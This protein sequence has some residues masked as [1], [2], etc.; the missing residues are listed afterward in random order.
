[1]TSTATVI[2]RR[3]ISP[4]IAALV[5]GLSLLAMT[6]IAI[7][8]NFGVVSN[9]AVPGDPTA[10]AA[11]LAEAGSRVRFAGAGFVIVAI[12][13]IIV[14]WALYIVLRSVNP[15][16]SLLGG[17]LRLAYAA[18]LAVA[19]NSLLGAMRLAQIEP[20]MAYLTLVSFNTLWQIGLIVFGVHLAVVGF[21]VWQADFI[22]W[23]FGLL[24][25]ISGLGYI[26][27]GFGF[28]LSPTYSLNVAMFTFLGE[29]AFMFW[30]LIQGRQLSG[31]AEA[32]ALI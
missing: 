15:G 31:S 8:V 12:L 6:V 28:L 19:V 2:P 3:D 14:A 1:V 17:W 4:Q 29:L 25:I 11:N 18:I 23:I 9:L 30:L 26:I 20:S 21:L 5:A 27:D 7:A 32:P 13:D 22:H 10:T 16:L 24:L